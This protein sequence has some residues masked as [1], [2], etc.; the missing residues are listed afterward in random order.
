[1]TI[2]QSNRH[3]LG[4]ER[5]ATGRVWRDRLDDRG[6]ARALALVQRHAVPELL[7]RIVGGRNAEVD[8]IEAYLDPTIKRLMPDPDVITGM[9]AAASRLADANGRGETVAV[10]GDSDVDGGTSAA[11]LASFLRAAGLDPPI[12]I[13]DRIFEGYGPNIEAI[14]ALA[15]RGAK[16][17]VTVDCGT[18]SLEPLAE[19]KRLGLDCVVIDHHLADEVL[20]DA[21]AIVNPNRLDDLSGLGHLAAVGLVFPNVV[22]ADRELRP[23]RR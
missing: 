14:R 7:A 11:V 3:F 17:I 5:S 12:H 9:T 21:V 15:E 8:G 6:N 22:A 20:P 23:R 13:P 2:L 19:A 1:M 10:F 16:L 4:V 18:T